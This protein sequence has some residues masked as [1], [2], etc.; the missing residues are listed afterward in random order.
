[1][2]CTVTRP[3]DSSSTATKTTKSSPWIL[4]VGLEDYAVAFSHLA[5]VLE[6]NFAA[7]EVCG[8]PHCFSTF[9]TA[10]LVRTSPM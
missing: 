9:R 8:M 3:F 7:A 6:C 10:N 1:M 2:S 5:G 4:P